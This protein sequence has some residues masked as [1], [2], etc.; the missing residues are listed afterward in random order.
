MRDDAPVRDEEGQQRTYVIRANTVI[1][2]NLRRCG[3][4]EKSSIMVT[5]RCDVFSIRGHNLNEQK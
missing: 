2:E 3:A 1:T 4:D 5:P